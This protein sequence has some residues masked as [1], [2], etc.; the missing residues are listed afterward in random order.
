MKKTKIL[1][2]FPWY[3][4]PDPKT[5]TSYF[6]ITHYFGRLQERSMWMA[7]T[8]DRAYAQKMIDKLPPLNLAGDDEGR[9]EYTWDDFDT[10]GELEFGQAEV[11][12]Y[13]LPG[14]A[15][16]M[17]VEAALTWGA[18]YLFMWDADML[19]LGSALLR[20]MRHK[21]PVVAALAFT[22]RF[23]PEP[24]I[25]RIKESKDEKGLVFKSETVFD[26]PRNRLIGSEDVDGSLAFGA[27][28]VLYNTNVFRQ[29]GK[30]WFHSTGCGEDWMFCVRLHQNGIPRYMDTGVKTMHR[31]NEPQWVYEQEY[32]RARENHP[33]A[34]EKLM[35]V[36]T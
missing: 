13:S 1:C 4:G 11:S 32:D 8:P 28:V 25:Y 29:M 19:L 26:Y 17:L 35:A 3:A 15:R 33:D 14:K 5:Y 10:F 34:Y 7:N 18:D 20:L 24:V 23:P 2:G 12:G 27:G 36:N 16:E 22:S 21:K 31:K 9:A 30:P 6:E